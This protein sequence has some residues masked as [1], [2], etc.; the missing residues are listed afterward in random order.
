MLTAK[1]TVL[2]NYINL[3]DFVTEYSDYDD[4]D[5]PYLDPES[6]LDFSDLMLQVPQPAFTED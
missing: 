4:E 6:E 3:W 1:E 2:Q 5:A